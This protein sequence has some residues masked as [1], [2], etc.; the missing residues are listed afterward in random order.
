MR[1]LFKTILPAVALA[2]VWVASG[3]NAAE[4]AVRILALGDSLTAGI[5]A[6]QELISGMDND[7]AAKIKDG[8][9]KL[10]S[11]MLST[12]KAEASLG[13]ELQ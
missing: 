7:N 10:D 2:I 12:F 8:F 9:N 3:A 5:A 4:R 13:N 6:V 1:R 11:A